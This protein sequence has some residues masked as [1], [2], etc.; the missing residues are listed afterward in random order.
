ML[1]QG[2]AGALVWQRWEEYTDSMTSAPKYLTVAESLAARIESGMLQAGDHLPSEAD[3][4]AEFG[5]SKATARNAINHLSQLGMIRVL[6]G[7]GSFVRALPRR[8]ERDSG[9][10]YELEKARVLDGLDQGSPVGAIELD[11]GLSAE[12]H[13]KAEYKVESADPDMAR[14]FGL[15]IG[16]PLL[17]REFHMG[18]LGEPPISIVV[19]HM[20]YE[21]VAQSPALLDASNEPWPGGTLHQ[22]ATV[23]IEVASI[24]DVVSAQMPT[25]TEARVLDMEPGTPLLVIRKVMR[26]ADDGRIVEHSRV[27]LPGD[28]AQTAYPIPL[29]PWPEGWT[30]RV[31]VIGDDG[32]ERSDM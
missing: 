5:V 22:L 1:C 13:A 17:R 29:K 30:D 15:A 28:R 10:R 24:T 12:P 23:G 27:A 3:V 20:P 14:A 26:A 7:R 25:M 31:E 8:I 32:D 21:Q 2:V 4:A 9:A 19:S 18:Y 6:H 16:A 11:A